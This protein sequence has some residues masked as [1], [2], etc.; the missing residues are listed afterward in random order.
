M[1]YRCDFSAQ[2]SLA[3]PG[4]AFFC[5]EQLRQL[6]KLDHLEEVLYIEN[7]IFSPF[8]LHILFFP[9]SSK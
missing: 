3:Q 7:R 8:L 2:P 5:L 9:F 6:G 1:F 4:R